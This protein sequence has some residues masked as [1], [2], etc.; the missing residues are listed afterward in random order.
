VAAFVGGG[1]VARLTDRPFLRGALRQLIL[2]AVAAGITFL[3]GSAV[4]AGV[5]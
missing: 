3:I 2:G 1:L 5:S 4:G